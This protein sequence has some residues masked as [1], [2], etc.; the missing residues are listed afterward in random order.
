MYSEEHNDPTR[1]ISQR[2]LRS[3]FADFMIHA[4]HPAPS[5]TTHAA[6]GSLSVRAYPIVHD[7]IHLGLYTNLHGLLLGLALPN[8]CEDYLKQVFF[9]RRP[10]MRG[11]TVGC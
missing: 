2:N 7:L 4:A 9:G 8:A 10:E 11:D 1:A 6:V 3:F 5:L